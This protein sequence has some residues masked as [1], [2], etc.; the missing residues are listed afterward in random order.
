MALGQDNIQTGAGGLIWLG[1]RTRHENRPDLRD[2]TPARESGS[3]AAL[4]CLALSQVI[5]FVGA[6]C[7][8][9]AF[10]QDN[11]QSGAGDLL[12]LGRRTRH[13]NRPDLR[14]ITPERESG[15]VA[16]PM[17]WLPARS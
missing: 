11:V 15:S 13:E 1:R 7:C 16:T 5:F 10:G 17:T 2:I 12:W 9:V 8:I 6:S 4:I 3:V 14:D